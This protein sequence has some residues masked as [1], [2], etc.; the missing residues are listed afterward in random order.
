MKLFASLPPACPLLVAR[1]LGADVHRGEDERSER[2]RD[3]REAGVHHRRAL[4]VRVLPFRVEQVAGPG[5]DAAEDGLNLHRARA[6]VNLDLGARAG[7]AR[8]RRRGVRLLGRRRVGGRRLVLL[9][10][11]RRVRHR[12]RRRVAAGGGS[13]TA[14]TPRLRGGRRLRRHRV[15]EGDDHAAVAEHDLVA[16]L[17]PRLRDALAVDGR[18]ARRAEVDDVDVTRA[19]RLDDA[20]HARHGLVVE[21]QVRRCE[22]PDLDRALREDLLAHQLVPLVDLE[23]DGDVRVGHGCSPVAGSTGSARW[24]SADC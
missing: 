13:L 3:G 17:Q 22:L 23:L 20:V 4:A 5:D 16:G 14:A 15:A 12:R 1:L 24:P 2:E 7:R 21:T 10:R 18:P 9:L 6:V 8:E 19:R 11:R